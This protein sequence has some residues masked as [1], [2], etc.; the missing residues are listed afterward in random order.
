MCRPLDYVTFFDMMSI[1]LGVNIFLTYAE[2][3]SFRTMAIAQRGWM[4][5]GADGEYSR[6]VFIGTWGEVIPA[7]VR[8]LERSKN[9]PTF[10]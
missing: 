5:K 1:L 8:R 6:N 3:S 7:P 9:V 10:G 2:I 4:G